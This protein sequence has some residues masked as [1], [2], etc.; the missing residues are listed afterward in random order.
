MKAVQ[1]EHLQSR[2]NKSVDFVSLNTTM[3][4]YD[5]HLIF[6]NGGTVIVFR[7]IVND[8]LTDFPMSSSL[9]Q[10]CS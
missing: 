5:T 10:F 7:L 6:P 8:R 9:P 3:S 4:S 2:I 1:D